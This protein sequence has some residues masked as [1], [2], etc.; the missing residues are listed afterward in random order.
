MNRFSNFM[1][2]C[3]AKMAAYWQS[4][5]AARRVLL[6]CGC[7]V[8]V[9]AAVA[10]IRSLNASP[11][12]IEKHLYGEEIFLTPKLRAYLAIIMPLLLTPTTGLVLCNLAGL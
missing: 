1:A 12:S 10:L 3:K 9:A 4:R 8:V 6:V 11:Q 5:S 7:I 2:S